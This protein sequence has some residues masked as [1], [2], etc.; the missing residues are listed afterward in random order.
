[1]VRLLLL[2]LCVLSVPSL[3]EAVNVQMD[4]GDQITPTADVTVTGSAT[5]ISA[6]N[7][8]RATLS[9]TNT[10]ATVNVR[11]GSSAVTASTGQRIPANSSA[12]IRNT[13]AV[14][15]ISEGA[16]VTVSC[17]EEIR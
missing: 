3:S 15:M 9:C 14:Y 10:S 11:W 12:E 13:G 4:D 8:N 2:L 16:N 17:T 5:L 6:A 7:S 1:M